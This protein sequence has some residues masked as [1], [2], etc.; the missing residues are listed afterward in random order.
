MTPEGLNEFLRVI[1]DF[2]RTE[3]V[4]L[5]IEFIRRPFRELLP[6]LREKREKVKALGLWAP[7]L[8]AATGTGGLW[9]KLYLR[10]RNVG[11]GFVE[12]VVRRK[13]QSNLSR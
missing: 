1:R 9:D 13:T 12:G 3:A 7:H 10:R 6:R 11:A 2:I 4:P 5:E 8:S